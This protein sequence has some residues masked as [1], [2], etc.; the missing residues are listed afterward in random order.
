M[1]RDIIERANEEL[2]REL[3]TLANEQAVWSQETFGS[4][5]ERG[6][7]G[8]LKHL[9]KEAKEAQDNPDDF[10]EY[11]DCLLLVLDSARRAG[12]RPMALVQAAREKMVVNKARL[13]S[14]PTDDNPV[15]HVR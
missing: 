2:G 1:S 5:S 13:W 7:I 10:S 12:L 9:E 6:P 8:P 3:Y 4:D 15:E 14:T 11:A